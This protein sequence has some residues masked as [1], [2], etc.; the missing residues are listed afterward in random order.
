[1]WFIFGLCPKMNH[2]LLLLEQAK[3]AQKSKARIA[4]ED[5]LY[6]VKVL[7]FSIKQF[8]SKM[9]KITEGVSFRLPNAELYSFFISTLNKKLIF[10]AKLNVE[11]TS[12]PC[13]GIT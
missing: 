11:R 6:N 3:R 4:G 10:E 5:W 12:S 1:M 8:L 13:Y 7:Y 9:S 2:S